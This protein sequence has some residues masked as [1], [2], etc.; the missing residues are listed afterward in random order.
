M[1]SQ[2]FLSVIIPAYNEEKRIVKTLLSLDKYLSERDYD[3]EILV[4]DDGSKDNTVNIVK[5]FQK[6]IKNLNLI[7][8]KENHGKGYVVRQGMLAA[9]GKYRLFTDA[10]NSTSPDQA[11]N[12]LSW[13]KGVKTRN[14]IVEKVGSYDIAIGSR[15]IKGARVALRQPLTRLLAGKASNLL[16]QLLALPGIWD[17]QCG[18]KIFTAKAASDIFKKATINRW[19]FDIEVLALGR[20]LGYAIKEVPVTWVNDPESKVS[21]KGYLNTFREL[22]KIRVNLWRN[23]YNI[24]TNKNEHKTNQNE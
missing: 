24:K 12:L 13:L 20:R 21:L 17:S 5:N 8:N 19:G 23:I 14:G 18:F 9:K 11:K 4:V 15:A 10:D 3:Y 22:F 6:M 1:P 7:E 16:I 2:K